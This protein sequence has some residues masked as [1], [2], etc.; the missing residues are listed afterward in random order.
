MTDFIIAVVFLVLAL[1]ILMERK[2]F[3]ALPAYELKRQAASGD[4]F[5]REIYPLV[6]YG[7]SFRALL[8]LLLGVFTAVSLVLFARLAPV[9]FGIIMV[10][11][12]L[13]LTFSWL[14]SIRLSKLNRDL[15]LLSVPIF[16]WVLHYAYP[17][18]KEL[19][20]LERYY[21]RDAVH[22]GLYE[23]EDLHKVLERQEVQLDNRIS[24]VQ[25][26]RLKKLLAFEQAKVSD[27][28]VEWSKVMKL[29]SEDFVGPKL[30]DEMH[31]SGQSA[32]PV[33]KGQSSKSAIGVLNKEEVGLMSEGR[34]ADHMHQPIV[35]AKQKESMESALAKFALSGQSLLLV[36]DNSVETV[37]VLTLKD[38]LG[39]LLAPA[40][41]NIPAVEHH[42]GHQDELAREL[43]LDTG[44]INESTE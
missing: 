25:L 39:S 19:G 28:M 20:K 9:W 38:A 30:L 17:L 31:K 43:D 40:G 7:S 22:T 4:K 37:G 42:P 11:I 36:T 26:G 32:F 6:S 10:A 35:H 2:A 29:N 34:V 18:I 41:R 14:P 24:A 44:G 16:A 23:P 15:A 8:W 1:V 5:A 21:I 13:W 12:V 33:M 3:F 27:Y